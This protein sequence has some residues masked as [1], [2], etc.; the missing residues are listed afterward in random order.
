[1]SEETSINFKHE[2]DGDR[3]G[4]HELAE[5]YVDFINKLD[6]NH[7]IALDAPWGTG[8]TTFINFMC[9]KFD[10]KKDVYIKFNSWENDF[11]QEPLLSLMSEI[12][13]QLEEKKY[14]GVDRAKVYIFKIFNF[15]KKTFFYFIN[16]FLKLFGMD[17]SK[18][19]IDILKQATKIISEKNSDNLFGKVNES[20]FLRKKFKIQVENFTKKI[21]EEKEKE[22][23]II[24]IDELDRCRPSFAIELLEN[25]KH[26]LDMK[27]IVFL[28]A[29]DNKQLSES[30]KSIYGAGFDADTYLH[31]FFDIELHLPIK[32]LSVFFRILEENKLFEKTLID[33]AKK[34]FLRDAVY[35]FNLTLRDIIRIINDILL[36]SVFYK[37]EELNFKIYVI[38]L[39]LKYKDK[40]MYQHLRNKKDHFNLTEIN[41]FYENELDKL[42]FFSSYF[43]DVSMESGKISKITILAFFRI[44]KTI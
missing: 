23:L 7:V 34:Q 19:A 39:I 42:D 6:G 24:V 32:N 20:K 21:L 2:F 3:L 13:S 29:V 10:E 33:G 8:K 30:I 25:I 11:T 26:L 41:K 44:E 5:K 18:D 36:L 31:R 1:M 14:I 9:E 40:N 22:K 43:K 15:F 38:L 28:I 35:A 4:R 12:I 16:L 27:E 17:I 37:K